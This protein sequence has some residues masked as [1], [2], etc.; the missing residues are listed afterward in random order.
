M[1]EPLNRGIIEM[2]EVAV[3]AVHDTSLVV[4]ENVNWSVAAGEFWVLAGLHHSGKSD[5]LRMTGGLTVPLAGSY[6][7]FGYETSLFAE[8]ELAVRLRLGFVFEG[9]QLFNQLTVAENVALPLRYHKNMAL[10]E[11]AQWV[12]ELLE[13]LE[14]TAFADVTPGNLAAN[15]RQRAALARALVLKPEVLLLDNPLR[16]LPGRQWEWW[17]QFLEQL[18]RGHEWLGARPMTLVVTTEELRH[19]RAPQRQFALLRDK[20]FVRVGAWNEVEA[21]ADP[22]IQELLAVPTGLTH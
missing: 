14:L 20:E 2:N 1:S 4:L 5:F 19:W 22:V 15:W 7:L 3:A 13:L 17:L 21:A 18:R 16:G 9:G 12:A 6:R 8:A 10:E 11:A